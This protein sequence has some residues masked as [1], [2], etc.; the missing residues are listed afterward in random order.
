MSYHVLMR[1]ANVKLLI[2]P[3]PGLE[4]HS[5][6]LVRRTGR[7]A[8][9]MRQFGDV[10]DR[11]QS[12]VLVLSPPGI[13]T[14]IAG[15]SAYS[16]YCWAVLHCLTLTSSLNDCSVVKCWDV[17]DVVEWKHS[18]TDC[19]TAVLKVFGYTVTSN[20]VRLKPEFHNSILFVRVLCVGPPFQEIGFGQC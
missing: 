6:M 12:T 17:S 3:V 14:I 7:D 2:C 20:T 16:R 13:C 9:T 1:P 4:E 10:S 19:K 5:S 18:A 11:H 15:T 8:L